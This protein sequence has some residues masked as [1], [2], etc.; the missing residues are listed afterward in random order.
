ME[1][2]DKN[3]IRQKVSHL[4]GPALIR[5][6]ILKAELKKY[7]ER[8]QKVLNSPGPFTM[9][10]PDND[11]MVISFKM[12]GLDCQLIVVMDTGLA[13]LDLNR[14][15]KTGSWHPVTE[16]FHDRTDGTVWCFENGEV[17]AL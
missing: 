7:V 2:I 6:D 8:L 17:K 12:K 14:V 15:T 5:N 4:E 3:Y 9:I 1:I 16:K 13:V 10:A 11:V